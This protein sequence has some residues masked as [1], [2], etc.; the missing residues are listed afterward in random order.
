MYCCERFWSHQSLQV[1]SYNADT[2][3]YRLDVQPYAPADRLVDIAPT[4]QRNQISLPKVNLPRKGSHFGAHQWCEMTQTHV[5]G[6]VASQAIP[7]LNLN[8]CRVRARRAAKRRPFPPSIFC[9]VFQHLCF[10]TLRRN[11]S[12]IESLGFLSSFTTRAETG[13]RVAMFLTL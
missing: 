11:Y 10:A 2:Q 3:S 4:R 1:E 13:D 9:T 7:S 6:V 8:A 12:I 5:L